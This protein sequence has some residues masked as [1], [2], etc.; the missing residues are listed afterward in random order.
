MPAQTSNPQ[1]RL[2]SSGR[3]FKHK[4]DIFRRRM[5]A[6]TAPDPTFSDKTLQFRQPRPQTSHQNSDWTSQ[7]RPDSRKHDI[8]AQTR[9]LQTGSSSSGRTA[10][11]SDQ[12]SKVRPHP[13]TDPKASDRTSKLKTGQSQPQARHSNSDRT[14]QPSLSNLG[15]ELTDEALDQT[16][17]DQTSKLRSDSFQ[18][19]QRKQRQGVKA[20]TG[21]PQPQARH[22]G[23]DQTFQ[24]RH[25]FS[26]RT[27]SEWTSRPR[28]EKHSCRTDIANQT[29]Q[30]NSDRARLHW[31]RPR[32]HSLGPDIQNQTGSARSVRTA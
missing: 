11:V 4:P 21:Q 5:Q 32:G 28:L 3:T 27:A 24:T 8:P 18:P 26:S 7:A 23:S 1:T 9:R 12:T 13:N 19:R 22:S 17:S 10:T 15:P 16:A 6:Q 25:T 14:C 30:I 2:P 31:K 20:Q 29:G